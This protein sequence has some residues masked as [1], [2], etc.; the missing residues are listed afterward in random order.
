MLRRIV[1]ILVLAGVAACEFPTEPPT[2]EQ[3]WV[4][5]VERIAINVAEL[6]PDGI[7]LSD[8]STA[9]EVQAPAASVS[10]SL[11]ELCG[12]PCLLA[13]GFEAPK[14]EFTDTLR[15]TT[16]L[17]ADLISASLAGGALD[18]TLAH[19]FSF[20][21]LRPSADT[22]AARGYIVVRVTSNGNEVAFD[23]IDGADQA[24]PASIALTPSLGVQP[25]VANDTVE[26]E[27]AIHSPA[28]DSTLIDSSD[29]LGISFAAST[30][31]IDETT[32]SATGI[33]ID[34]VSTEMD[35]GDVDSATVSR[36]Q[37]GA[38]RFGVS[39]PFTLSGTLDMTF[40]GDFQTIQHS[41][42]LEEGNYGERLEFTGDEVRAILGSDSV[43]TVSSGSV[44]ADDGTVTVSPLD[45]LT[46]DS[47]FELVI[48][49]GPTEEQ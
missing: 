40:R 45:A 27:I 33:D 18:A 29:T 2:F 12:N 48:L 38:L 23:S 36:V 4:V 10:L 28:G 7:T 25:V 9:F 44:S 35:F 34:S 46:L 26:M 39:N 31:L 16:T 3:V 30:L 8:D 22:T 11:L 21:P 15:T 5:P 6:L 19:S 37:R 1:V 41:L 47:E 17:P 20:D 42:T 13:S 32:I 49:V 14:P 24:F 43:E